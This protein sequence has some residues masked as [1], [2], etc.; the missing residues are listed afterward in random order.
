MIAALSLDLLVVHVLVPSG[1]N[2]RSAANHTAC[3]SL[4]VPR[5]RWSTS[6]RVIRDLRLHTCLACVHALAPRRAA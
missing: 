5:R 2:V 1:V 3:G 4:L 6:S